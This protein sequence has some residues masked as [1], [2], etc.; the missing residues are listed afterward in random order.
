[1]TN[2]EMIAAAINAEAEASGADPKNVA[3]V[4][5]LLFGDAACAEYA[6]RFPGAPAGRARQVMELA[7]AWHEQGDAKSLWELDKA[8]GRLIRR[9]GPGIASGSNRK[10]REG[11]RLVSAI[12]AAGNAVN[13][14]YPLTCVQEAVECFN[15]E[16]TDV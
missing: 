1:M 9:P 5:A 13:T 11:R 10:G 2:D 4:W 12:L 15:K 6:A 14:M 8:K 3:K 7:K 16:L